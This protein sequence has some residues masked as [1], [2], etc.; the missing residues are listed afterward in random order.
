MI[1]AT[2]RVTIFSLALILIAGLAYP[3]V[4]TGVAQTIF[5]N[6]A[7]GSL[8]EESGKVIGSKLIA[9]NFTKPGYFHPRPSTAGYAADNSGASNLSVTNK[10][11]NDTIA[12]R[13]A[14]QRALSGE[15]DSK[16][17]VP[18]DMVMASGSGLDPHITPEAAKYQAARVAAARNIDIQEINDLIDRMTEGRTWGILGMPRV[19]V[20]EINREL[21]KIS[22]E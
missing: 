10:G 22:S 4:I 3:L 15:A 21:D 19:N 1:A 6:R 8:I 5:P 18:A 17:K 13:V 7:N 16:T 20:L 14:A 12:E 9:Q 11:L 2:F